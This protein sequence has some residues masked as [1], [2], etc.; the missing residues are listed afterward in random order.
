M[1]ITSFLAA[2]AGVQAASALEY[3]FLVNSSKGGEIS[4]GMA[5]YADNHSPG[6]GAR[7]SDYTDVTHGSNIHWE[8]K[9]VKGTFGTGV[10][11][12]S[13]IF[14]DAASKRANAWA[15]TATNGFRN[16]NCY[17]TSNPGEKPYVLYTVDGWSVYSIYMCR[18]TG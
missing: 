11:F 8:G 18:N 5:Y 6:N 2:L 17:K 16:F 13:N 4:S 9:A 3:V 15:G 12:T 1:K 14:A 7:P 10:S